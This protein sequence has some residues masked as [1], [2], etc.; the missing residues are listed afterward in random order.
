MT[1]KTLLQSQWHTQWQATLSYAAND[2]ANDKQHYLF[3][4]ANDIVNDM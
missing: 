1:C 2:I 3:Y 4:A